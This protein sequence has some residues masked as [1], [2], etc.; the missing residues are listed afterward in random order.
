LLSGKIQPLLQ[1]QRQRSKSTVVGKTL[2]N[3]A[4]VGDPER[5]LEAGSNFA[6]AF[7]EQK[8]YLPR[9]SLRFK[10]PAQFFRRQSSN[11][12][13]FSAAGLAGR[14]GNGRAGHS[15]KICEKFDAGLI[16]P[17][18]ERRRSHRQFQGIT[19]D[20]SNRILLRV[21]MYLN[22]ENGPSNSIA[23]WN[24]EAAPANISTRQL[25]PDEGTSSLL[26]TR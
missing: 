24:H 14:Y 1:I 5:A 12:N 11:P 2:K 19:D 26:L 21:R 25:S 22:H 3:L 15:K 10:P 9:D 7:R 17:S 23:D 6:Q 16:R 4:D 20:S 18:I 13:Q 8:Q